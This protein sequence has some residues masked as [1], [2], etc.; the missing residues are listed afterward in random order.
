MRDPRGNMLAAFVG[1]VLLVLLFFPLVIQLLQNE[2]KQAVKKSKATLAFQLGEVGVSKGVAKL[3]ENWVNWTNAAAGV[4]IAGY[5][6][7]RTYEDVNGGSYKVILT[8]GSTPGTVLVVGKGRDKSTQEVRVIE[9]EYAPMNPD[10]GLI[11]NK[12]FSF[13]ESALPQVHWGAVRSY[14]NFFGTAGTAFPRYFSS[15]ATPRDTDPT[16]PNTNNVDNWSFQTNMG[17]HPAPDLAYYK[18]KAMNSTVPNT[19]ATGQISRSDGNPVVRNPPNSGYFQVSLNPG[20]LITFDKFSALPELLGNHY[21]FRS[22]TSVLYFETTGSSFAFIRRAFLDVEAVIDPQGGVSLYNSNIPFHVFR[23][24]IPATA[25]VHYEGTTVRAGTTGVAEWNN[26]FVGVYAQPNHCCYDI[27]NVQIHGY[28]YSIDPDL[29]ESSKM[30][31]ILQVGGNTGMF[32]GTQV[33]FDPAVLNKVVWA[34][35]PIH[36]LSWKE[37]NR[38]W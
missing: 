6:D 17:S 22:S 24:T 18:A 37:T 1:I 23:A 38:S 9:A 25:P 26:N 12:G 16:P 35:A 7:D 11:F 13:S 34:N 31:G 2:S 20:N 32:E 15:G 36:L 27:P 30:V 28:F 29:R 14:G 8:P 4:P 21:E 3:S 10:T 19:S 5:R 33:Y